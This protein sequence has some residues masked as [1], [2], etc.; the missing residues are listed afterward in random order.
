MVDAISPPGSREDWVQSFSVNIPH[1]DEPL[2]TPITPDAGKVQIWFQDE[3]GNL[4][5]WDEA[6]DQFVEQ[7]API[8]NDTVINSRGHSVL[9]FR[10]PGD[11]KNGT[12]MQF[13]GWGIRNGV[14]FGPNERVVSI[15]FPESGSTD[16]IEFSR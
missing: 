5:W 11:M 10:I 12:K 7:E 16:K 13:K 9:E 2:G 3:D 15:G 1:A 6:T 8:T 4:H 14:A